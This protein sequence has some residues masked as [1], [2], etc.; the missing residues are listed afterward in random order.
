MTSLLTRTPPDYAALDFF[1]LSEAMIEEMMT[2]PAYLDFLNREW[3]AEQQANAA[4]AEATADRAAERRQA[5]EAMHSA[6]EDGDESCP[7]W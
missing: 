7:P 3:Y 2:D 1:A 6:C 5:S 4:M